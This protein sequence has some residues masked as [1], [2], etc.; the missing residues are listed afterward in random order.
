MNE[1]SYAQALDAGIEPID[2]RADHLKA[3]GAGTVAGTLDALVWAKRQRCLMALI[4]LESGHKVQVSGFQLNRRPH[5]P[6]YMGLR[7]LQPGR[8]VL[9]H[10]EMGPRGGVHV[11]VTRFEDQ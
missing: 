5:L 4:T 6:S 11:T 9:L 10:I 3:L 1:L 2:Y 7:D 8:P